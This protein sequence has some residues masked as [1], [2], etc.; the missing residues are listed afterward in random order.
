MSAQS[1]EIR[2]VIL[3]YTPAKQIGLPKAQC[4]KAAAASR[5]ADYIFCMRIFTHLPS[6]C[7]SYNTPDSE[8]GISGPDF[9]APGLDAHLK[10]PQPIIIP[11]ERRFYLL[12]TLV[13]GFRVCMYVARVCDFPAVMMYYMLSSITSMAYLELQ[14]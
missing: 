11:G 3:T 4:Q 1:L 5:T 2:T 6:K 10:P 9:V 14:M 13:S 7:V 12:F 8:F